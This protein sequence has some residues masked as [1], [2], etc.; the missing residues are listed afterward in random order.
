V[1]P[2]F[3]ETVHVIRPHGRTAV[4]VERDDGDKR[5]IPVAW[6]DLRPRPEPLQV[7]GRS[8]RLAPAAAREL[9]AWVAERSPRSTGEER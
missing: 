9:S 3:G 5:L 2:W 1:H 8:V 6:T 7:R 4:F